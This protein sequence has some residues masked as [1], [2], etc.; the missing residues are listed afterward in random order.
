MSPRTNFDPVWLQIQ[1]W[2]SSKKNPTPAKSSQEEQIEDRCPQEPILIQCGSKSR[3]GVAPRKNP[4]PAKS[5]RGNEALKNEVEGPLSY[6][7]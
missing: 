4:T 1:I 7:L 3:Y 2:R 6:V 5:H